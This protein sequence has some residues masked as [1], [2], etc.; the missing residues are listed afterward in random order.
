MTTYI[1]ADQFFYPQGIRKGGYL[2]IVD[3]SYRFGLYRL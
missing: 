2:E 1:Q 3:G